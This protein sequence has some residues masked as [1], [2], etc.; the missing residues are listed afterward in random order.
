MSLEDRVNVLEKKYYRLERDL[1]AKYLL[2]LK[3]IFSY[4]N[5]VPIL[6]GSLPSGFSVFMHNLMQPFVKKQWEFELDEKANICG[7]DLKKKSSWL[8]Q[9]RDEVHKVML[10]KERMVQP[11]EIEKTQ[12][13]LLDEII[14]K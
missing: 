14:N 7:L 12:L 4:L 11:F 2:S 13:T 10:E 3:T 8:L 1:N 6:K 5:S 9:K